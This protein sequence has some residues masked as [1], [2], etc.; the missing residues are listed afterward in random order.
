MS[1]S[2]GAAAPSRMDCF[3]GRRKA[4]LKWFNESYLECSMACHAA[5]EG[6]PL[7]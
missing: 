5:E 2:Y 7:L 3:V 4:L 6:A 1:E